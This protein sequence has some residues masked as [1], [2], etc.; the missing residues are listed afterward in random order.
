MIYTFHSKA[1]GNVIYLE[2][3]G[4][5]VLAAMGK[6]ADAKGILTVE[7]LAA[8]LAGIEAQ[9]ALDEKDRAERKANGEALEPISFR[10]RSQPMAAMIRAAMKA[11]EAIVWGV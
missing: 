3:P 10:V 1:S 7:Q 6:D 11:K 4:K 5:Q 9:T 2:G 8:A